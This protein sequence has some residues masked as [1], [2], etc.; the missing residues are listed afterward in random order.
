MGLYLR[1]NLSNRWKESWCACMSRVSIDRSYAVSFS[2]SNTWA[3]VSSAP[4]RK[5]TTSWREHIVKGMNGQSRLSSRLDYVS[6]WIWWIEA[7]AFDSCC[8]SGGREYPPSEHCKSR[9]KTEISPHNHHHIVSLTDEGLAR[10][11]FIDINL[12]FHMAPKLRKLTFISVNS[13]NSFNKLCI[14]NFPNRYW[15]RR[16]AKLFA[17]PSEIT[18]STNSRSTK[19][20]RI[21]GILK[22]GFL[23]STVK[24]WSFTTHGHSVKNTYLRCCGILERPPYCRVRSPTDESPGYHKQQGWTPRYDHPHLGLRCSTRPS[25]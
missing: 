16:K 21:P 22:M 2:D 11:R 13:W 23:S 14:V 25:A 20:S 7:D 24:I 5:M 1:L 8:W 3:K 19:Y 10:V 9:W 4:S 17:G 15:R 18:P 12:F 6:F